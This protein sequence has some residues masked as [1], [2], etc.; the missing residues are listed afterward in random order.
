M[1]Y[2]IWPYRHLVFT[3]GP[4]LLVALL[5][6]FGWLRWRSYR[7]RQVPR[8]TLA[9]AER[10]DQQELLKARARRRPVSREDQRMILRRVLDQVEGRRAPGN[11]LPPPGRN[12]AERRAHLQAVVRQGLRVDAEFAGQ[13]VPGR[14]AFREE[15]GEL[16]F[17][18]AAAERR[19]TPEA[20]ATLAFSYDLPSGRA[21]F[22]TEVVRARPQAWILAPP[23]A[24]QVD[25]T[26]QDDL[27]PAQAGAMMDSLVILLWEQQERDVLLP[28]RR[29]DGARLVADPP[30]GV[31][32]PAGER[33]RG[34][35]YVAGRRYVGVSGRV[36][37]PQDG[38][39]GI[40]LLAGG[41]IRWALDQLVEALEASL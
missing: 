10:V 2:E 28:V 36:T 5:A 17:E 30:A 19:T 33:I 41:D 25:R 12:S 15:T 31:D 16:S 40:E 9:A 13:V 22:M 37:G 18:P 21:R 29:V 7:Q 32:L 20:G 38:G 6:F 35:I 34:W 4:I 23:P 26:D 1:L 8:G 3:W 24:I 39:V 14:L 11:D 27:P